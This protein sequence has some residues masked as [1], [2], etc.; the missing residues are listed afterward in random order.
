MSTSTHTKTASS[1]ASTTCLAYKYTHMG[2]T[3]T[4]YPH[5]QYDCQRGCSCPT[6]ASCLPMIDHILSE[7]HHT[8]PNALTCTPHAY[9]THILA[10]RGRGASTC[11]HSTD[12]NQARQ[13]NRLDQKHHGTE[14]PYKHVSV[15]AVQALTMA[16]DKSAGHPFSS[17]YTCTQ[18]PSS[19]NNNPCA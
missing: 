19:T 5:S 7:I 18:E 14:Q 6:Y 16:V 1:P 12:S 2:C 15:S 11:Q 3:C 10:Y 8:C 9:S 4:H 13:T 17:R